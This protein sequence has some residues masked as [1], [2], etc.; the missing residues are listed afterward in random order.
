MKSSMSNEL[1][2]PERAGGPG[3]PL[4]LPAEGQEWVILHTKPRTEKKAE[5]ALVREGV[6]T[7]LPLRKKD[8]RYGGRLRSFWSPLFPGYVFGLFQTKIVHSLRF[9]PY[10]AN[11]LRVMDQATLVHQLRQIQRALEAGDMIEVMPYLEK[12]KPVRVTAG[13][14]KGV[15]GI[16]ERIAKKTKVVISIEMI[17]QSVF[18]EVDSS[19]IEAM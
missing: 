3:G 17:K 9:N 8:H 6:T 19:C 12:G 4:P 14:L 15:E 11:V 18:V 2:S 5:Q 10:V 1:D 13:P 16:V 7:Y